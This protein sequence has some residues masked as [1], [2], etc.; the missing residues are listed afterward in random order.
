EG[1]INWLIR[2]ALVAAGLALVWPDVAIWIRLACSVFFV[3]VFIY[4]GRSANVKVANSVA[5]PV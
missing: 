3:G 4:S 1:E 5:K 2:V